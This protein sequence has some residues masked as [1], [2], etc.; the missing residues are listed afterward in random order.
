MSRTLIIFGLV[1]PVAG[2]TWPLIDRL[3]LGRLPGDIAIEAEVRPAEVRPAEDRPAEVRPHEVRLPEVRLVEVRLCEV[4][5][6]KVCDPEVR[7]AEPAEVRVDVGVL[8]TPRVPGDRALLEQ[9]DVLVVRHRSI[10][11][12]IRIFSGMQALCKDDPKKLDT[13]HGK[14]LGC[15][16]RSTPAR[17]YR[18]P[19]Q[20]P[21]ALGRPGP[22]EG[23]RKPGL[24]VLAAIGPIPGPPGGSFARRPQEEGNIDIRK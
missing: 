13:A 6:A 19:W 10:P 17:T 16:M 18:D 20:L 22:S 21:H 11:V 7:P 1:L 4:L 2:V 12:P 14:Q 23:V 3:G 24:R 15:R 5:P 8:V 9:C